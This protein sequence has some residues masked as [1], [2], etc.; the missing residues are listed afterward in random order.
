MRKK[1]FVYI[2][3]RRGLSETGRKKNILPKIG[4]PMTNQRYSIQH[5]L[6]AFGYYMNYNA[7]FLY[8]LF[9]RYNVESLYNFFLY[10]FYSNNHH[11]S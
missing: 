7:I 5:K 3:Y 2:L 10:F 8:K 1:V 9:V 4:Y 11:N 6:Y